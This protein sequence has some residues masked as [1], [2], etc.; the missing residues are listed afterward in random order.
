MKIV[1]CLIDS[2]QSGGIERSICSKA[3][4]LADEL[5]YDIT[6]VTT[7]RKNKQNFYDFSPNIRFI[8][9]HINYFELERQSFF[10]RIIS[11]L[12]KR[13]I[14]RQKLN[15]VLLK[16]RPDI[17]ISTYSHEFT[18]LCGMKDGSKKI[19]EHHLNKSSVKI[20]YEQESMFSL[21]RIFALA[22]EMRKQW[23]IRKYDAFVVLTHEARQSWR[24]LKNIHVIPNILPFYPSRFSNGECKRVISAGRLTYQ[25]GYSLLIKAWA[26]IARRYPDWRLDI[27]GE[28]RDYNKLSRMIFSAGMHD[29]VVIHSPDKN[30][31]E[32]YINSSLYVMPS[33]YEGFGLV[34]IEVMACGLPCVSFDCPSG[35]SEIISHGEDG[36]LVEYKN[37]DKLAEA[38]AFLIEDKTLRKEMGENARE[39][40]ERFLPEKIMP[41]WISLF[42]QVTGTSNY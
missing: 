7:D 3:N 42:E 8:D 37:I 14:H 18:I 34:L 15:D 10:E 19:A 29:K 22:V 11:L 2:S 28:G 25:K 16:L 17:A 32:E 33:L 13:R 36:L 23:Y 38:I 27:Y 24:D 6:I 26:K 40:S 31:E 30:I 21:E 4:Y 12:K 9:L 41:R 20:A 5:G 39:S 1:Y 35:P